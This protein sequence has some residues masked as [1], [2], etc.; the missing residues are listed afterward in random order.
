[1]KKLTRTILLAAVLV[2]SPL[3]AAADEDSGAGEGQGLTLITANADEGFAL[4][5]R[6]ARRSVTTI[7]T[8]KSVLVAERPAYAKNAN[9]L[10]AASEVVAIHFQTIA[11]AN[12]YWRDAGQ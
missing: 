12:G 8:D 3:L 10:I 5:I 4:A 7:Q 6:L 11:A 9:G 2:N 1:M